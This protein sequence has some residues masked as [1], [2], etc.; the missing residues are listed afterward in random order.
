M[1]AAGVPIVRALRTVHKRGRY[2]RLFR[3]IEAAVSEGHSLAD[4]V[5]DRHR[6]FQKLDV[7]LIRAG[8]ETG[9]LPEML[10]ELSQWY[11]FRQWMNRVIVAGLAY[12][13]MM[14]HALAFIAP[15]VPFALNEFDP[16]V[17]LR[18]MLTILGIFYI[19]VA[20]IV[21]VKMFSPKR[22]PLRRGLDMGVM[23]LPLLGRA[24]RE[25]ELSRYTKVFAVT[26]RAGVPIIRCAEIATEAVSNSVM[27]A[28]L[29]G[30]VEKARS[31]Q[32]LSLGFSSNLPPEFINLW[33]VGEE[34]GQ[35]DDATWRLSKMHA[36]NAKMRFKLIAEWTPRIIY[37]IVACVMIYYIFTG[38]SKIYGN[39]L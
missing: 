18:A 35:L 6:Q 16:S 38:F 3:D 27:A 8:E 17:Y 10:A 7:T 30:A 36:E 15:V 31:G 32:E 39:I 14:I 2:G 34:S 24:V 23:K 12:P 11:T 25:L 19:P 26:F 20:V 28:Q 29:Q 5:Q 37:A 33:Q 4:A 9:Q 1:L 22:G 21:A 13:V